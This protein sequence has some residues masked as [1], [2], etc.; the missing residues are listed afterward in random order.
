MTFLE[1]VFGVACGRHLRG[2]GLRKGNVAHRALDRR[3]A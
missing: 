2:A 3:V 1:L